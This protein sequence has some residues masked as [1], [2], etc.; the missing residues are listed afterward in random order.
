MRDIEVTCK[1]CNRIFVIR[2]S[3]QEA[4]SVRK[5]PLSKYCPICRREYYAKKE[6]ERKRQEDL[7]WQKNKAAELQKYNENLSFMQRQFDIISIEEV[8]PNPQDK[9][10]YVIGNGFDLMHGVRSS[11]YEF[12]STLGKHSNIR[13]IL[14]KYIEVDDLWADFEGALAKINV[15]AMSQPY[16]LDVML[17]M[18]DAYDEDAQAAD[19]FA[20][21]EM[22]ASPATELSSEL[23]DRFT[24]WIDSLKV[25]TDDRPLKGIIQ[26]GKF[27]D[28]NYTEFVEELYGVQ[29]SDVCYI[30]GCRRKQK[31]E[32]REELILGHQP[33]ASDPQ[34]DFEED[35]SGINLSGNRAQMIY[36]AQQVALREIVD[37]DDDL[38]KHCDKIIAAH[39]SFFEAI[40]DVDKV[41]TIGHSL[42][43]VDWDYFAEVIK[44]NKDKERINWYFGCFSNGD[45]ER[46]QNFI[47]QF[48]IHPDRVHIFRTDMMSVT[49]HK[50]NAEGA[51]AKEQYEKKLVTEKKSGRQKSNVTQEKVIGE[52]KNRRWKVCVRGNEI[53]L[54]DDKDSVYSNKDIFRHHEWCCICR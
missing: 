32:P 48:D 34:F 30:H 25:N 14:E 3:E 40:S 5:R 4:F 52:S 38:T 8:V 12:G 6:E 51:K 46:I 50:E 36:D 54:K 47:R 31:G 27:L 43:P 24:K 53:D 15:E 49:V 37:A 45:L 13:F 17:D 19:F 26:K 10:L 28:F 1:K 23:K 42:Y 39:K 11:Y 18:M 33:H 16:I 7:V 44:R 21:A 29:R 22:A 9:V 35:W 41:I 2:Q 20:A